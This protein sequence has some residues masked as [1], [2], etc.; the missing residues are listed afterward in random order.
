MSQVLGA[1]WLLDFTMLRPVLAWRAF[2]NVWN[3]YLFNFP[4]FLG[5]GKPRILNQWIRGHDCTCHFSYRPSWHLPPFPYT[6]APSYISGRNRE[7]KCVAVGPTPM[8]FSDH[9]CLLRRLQSLQHP[10]DTKFS[11]SKTNATR[12]SETSEQTYYR[13]RFH[14]QED[15]HKVNRNISCIFVFVPKLNLI[16]ALSADRSLQNSTHPGAT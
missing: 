7:C 3:V 6:T 9:V 2:W 1:F 13:Q 8:W 16:A 10:R 15:W 12:S 14:N 4:F 5:R 11:N